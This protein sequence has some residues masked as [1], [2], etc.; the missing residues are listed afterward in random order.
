MS[1]SHR[2][3][4]GLLLASGSTKRPRSDYVRNGGLLLPTSAAASFYGRHGSSVIGVDVTATRPGRASA[5]VATSVTVRAMGGQ[6]TGAT[7]R[8]VPVAD[9]AARTITANALRPTPPPSRPDEAPRLVDGGRSWWWWPTDDVPTARKVR[10]MRRT[11]R[12]LEDVAATY[13]AAVEAGE[14]PTPAVV[15]RFGPMEARTAR[16]WIAD[17][18]A[19]GHDMPAA[20]RRPTT[21]NEGTR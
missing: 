3:E 15:A 1:E 18:R 2:W 6:V 20:P 21:S 10:R 17:A 11:D 4:W 19:A 14:N 8:A 13:R 16:R 9:L 5:P 12:P 7:M